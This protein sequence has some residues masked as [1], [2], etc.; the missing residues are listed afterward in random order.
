MPFFNGIWVDIQKPSTDAIKISPNNIS[1]TFIRANDINKEYKI[2]FAVTVFSQEYNFNIPGVATKVDMQ[3]L[4]N[5][6]ISSVHES[7]RP[8]FLLENFTFKIAT[9]KFLWRKWF[10]DS[11]TGVNP[12]THLSKFERT[13]SLKRQLPRMIAYNFNPYTNIFMV[14]RFREL[15]TER[16]MHSWFDG[17]IPKEYQQKI[18]IKIDNMFDYSYDYQFNRIVL[19]LKSIYILGIL[20]AVGYAVNTALEKKQPYIRIDFEKKTKGKIKDFD[21][22]KWESFI[23]Q[24]FF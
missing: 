5:A 9:F 7:D 10:S 16:K 3:S 15:T 24:K 2:T 22:K 17:F 19:R 6:I 1:L 4:K 20:F 11:L 8:Y 23:K 14:N 18:N 21:R 12:Q 13:F